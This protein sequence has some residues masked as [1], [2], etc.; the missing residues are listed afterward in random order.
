MI[1]SIRHRG[2]KRLYERNDP[3]KVRAGH[4]ARLRRILFAL[5]HATVPQDMGLPGFRI[6]PLK[7]NRKGEWA[8][9]VSDNWRVT[10]AFRDG[11][12]HDVD[13]EDYH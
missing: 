8:V 4:A 12:V 6:H 1:R 2:L 10:F 7:G 11:H 13:Y 9:D 5:D 3:S